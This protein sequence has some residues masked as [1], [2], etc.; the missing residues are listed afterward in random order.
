MADN[1]L[2]TTKARMDKSIEA[3]QR[4]LGSI[5]AGVANAS[6]LDRVSVE[7]YGA[8][9]PLNQ[10]ASITIPEPRML[11]ISPYDKGSL[12]DIEKGILMSDVGITPNNDGDVIRLTIP[13]LTKERREDLVKVVGKE[14]ENAKISVRNIRRDAID[15]CK[16]MEKNNEL[17]EDD[18]KRYE[19]DIQKLTDNATDEI[20]R[21]AKV[22]EEEIRNN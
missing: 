10:L 2:K 14:Q 20:D 22:K 4:E 5:R 8:P 13:A 15:D 21:L 11:M 7:Y 1:L 12:K 16:K 3:F 6:I 17:T 9:T 19:K 18:V